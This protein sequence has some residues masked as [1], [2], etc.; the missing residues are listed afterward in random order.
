M[1]G[2][3]EE[4]ATHAK[5]WPFAFS[6]NVRNFTCRAEWASIRE[7]ENPYAKRNLWC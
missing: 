3:E 7:S 4:K 6:I 2:L 5:K 1:L